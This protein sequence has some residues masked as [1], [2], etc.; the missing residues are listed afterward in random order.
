MTIKK[1]NIASLAW[2]HVACPLAKAADPLSW[3]MFIGFWAIVLCALGLRFLFEAEPHD[4]YMKYYAVFWYGAW[5]LLVFSTVGPLFNLTRL[6]N[7]VPL[8]ILIGVGIAHLL[9]FIVIG[10]ITLS[11]TNNPTAVTALLAAAA[12][13]IMVGI[14]WVVQHQSS[15]KASRRA[16]T[17]GVLMQSRLSKEFQ[18]QVRARA[19]YYF[20]GHVVEAIDATL[21]NR[22]GLEKK[23]NDLKADMARELGIVKDE[24]RQEIIDLYK[25]KEALINKKYES[26]Q[27][28]KYLLN[29][30]EFICAGIVLRELDEPMLKETLSDIAVCLYQD[31][32]HVR[33]LAKEYQPDVFSNM[34]RVIGQYWLSKV[35]VVPDEG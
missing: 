11:K 31:S 32:K 4:F 6:R 22:D 30:Y 27:G 2:R 14:G 1:E 8:G 5:G 7:E 12:A 20:S 23:L 3:L 21:L 19:S 24:A 13:A 26:I 29:F 9:A 28:V 33:S 16:H 17:F 34:E 10:V 18:E 25:E 35:N 15:A